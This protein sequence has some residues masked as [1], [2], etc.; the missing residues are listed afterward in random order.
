MS[1][2][3][4]PKHQLDEVRWI[5]TDDELESFC[6]QWI[7]QPYICIDTEFIRIKT[8]Y[9]IA[10]LIQVED[11]QGS[12][13]IDPLSINNWQPLAQLLSQPLVLK[14]MHAMSEDIEVFQRLMPTL[15]PEALVD[16]QVAAALL[17]MDFQMSFQK[18]IKQTLNIN[19][20]KNQTR[21]NWLK[22]PLC[23]EQIY[24]AQEDVHYLYKAY[25]KLMLKLKT[26]NRESWLMQECESILAEANLSNQSASYYTRIKLAWKLNSQQLFVLKQLAIWRERKVQELDIVRSKFVEDESLW[27]IA[28]FLSKEESELKLA[29]LRADLIQQYGDEILKLV[30]D[31]QKIDER[32]WPK[33]LPKPLSI[34]AGE[35]YKQ[36]RKKVVELAEKEGIT[37]ELLARKKE[38]QLLIRSGFNQKEHQ[39]PSYFKGWRYELVGKPLLDWL[40]NQPQI[41]H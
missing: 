26:L 5:T 4:K 27:R 25:P 36:L 33:P 40:A 13:F 15:K 28:R 31:A 19:L 11:S 16:T 14:V 23:A 3:F 7:A 9:P 35:R 10:G 1:A 38:L 8:Y 32:H 20:D 22:R 17:N 21:S 30:A 29:G 37:P 24:Y 39:L 2:V 12:Y 34:N 6:A 18:L 41:N